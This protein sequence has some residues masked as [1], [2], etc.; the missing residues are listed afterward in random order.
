VVAFLQYISI[1]LSKCIKG[2]KYNFHIYNKE[3]FSVRQKY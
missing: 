3:R 1:H 2:L